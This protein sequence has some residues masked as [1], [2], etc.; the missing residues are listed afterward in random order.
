MKRKTG[1]KFFTILSLII[2][3]I[4]VCL[5]GIIVASRVKGEIP[6]VF[7]YSFH[8]VVTDS[9]TPEINA[10]DMVIARRNEASEI[11][12]GDDVVFVSPDPALNGI[13]IVHRVVDIR[14]DGGLITQG[15]KNGAQKDDYPVYDIKGKVVKVSPFL[16]KMF[17]GLEKN[18]NI[19]F[20]VVLAVFLIVILDEIF[21]ITKELAAKKV[22]AGRKKKKPGQE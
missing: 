5:F 4:S 1:R 21:F 13:T 8:I 17:K 3:A 16:G 6:G 22:E 14:E 12:V 2:F 15:I 11:A 10:G 18:R 19:V 20:G 9:M 7:G